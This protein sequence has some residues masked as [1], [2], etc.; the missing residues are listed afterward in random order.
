MAKAKKWVKTL[1]IAASI[2]F[3]ALCVFPIMSVYSGGT[4]SCTLY[5]RGFN[6]MEFSAWG[7]IPVF[8]T[9][10]IPIIALGHQ[11]REMKE[12]LFLTLFTV[13]AVS[14]ARSINAA[15]TW[16][17]EVGDSLIA[18][19]PCGILFPLGFIIVLALAKIL[20]VITIKEQGKNDEI[21][22]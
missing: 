21:S 17:Y 2:V 3:S 10:L 7:V 16:L 20:D 4:E 1:L 5:V 19:Y 18:Y 9:F 13:N 8:A 6:L 12:I 22:V 11:S 15:R 14:Y